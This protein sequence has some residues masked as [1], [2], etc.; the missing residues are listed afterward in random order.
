MS[1]VDCK[2]QDLEN[3][4]SVK[5]RGA[6]HRQGASLLPGSRGGRASRDRARECDAYD[7]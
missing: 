3:T 2:C 5:S 1:K 6:W 7:G 4:V